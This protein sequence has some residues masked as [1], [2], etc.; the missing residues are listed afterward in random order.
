MNNSFRRPFLYTLSRTMLK[1]AWIVISLC[2]ALRI[3]PG[4]GG[5]MPR[6]KPP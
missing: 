5:R 2:V 4:V 6:G 1:L 3:D